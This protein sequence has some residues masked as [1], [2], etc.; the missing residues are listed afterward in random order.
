MIPR[1]SIEY[2]ST[3][4]FWVAVIA[5]IVLAAGNLVKT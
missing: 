5:Y 4:A 2:V 1:V 3:H